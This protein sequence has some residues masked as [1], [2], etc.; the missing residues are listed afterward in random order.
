MAF[1]RRPGVPFLLRLLRVVSLVVLAAIGTTILMREAPGYFTDAR[2]TD[3]RYAG[4]ARARLDRQRQQESSLLQLSVSTLRH[5]SHGDLGQSRQ[6]GLSVTSMI[7]SRAAASVRLLF[8][9]VAAGWL[10]SLMLA[11]PLA[12]RRGSRGEALIAAPVAVMLAIPTGA[13]ATLCLL[14]DF[15]GPLLVLATI[16]AVRD[17][18]LVYRLLRQTWSDPCLLHARAQGIPTRRILLIHLL[19][20]L[21]SRLIAL[22]SMSFVLALSAL[23]PVEVIFNVPGL[24][25][26]A[27]TAAMNRDLPVLLAVTMVMAACVGAAGLAG[28]S[29]QQTELA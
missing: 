1:R 9:S 29:L 6:Y 19:P 25:Q 24:G 15:G 14:A 17:F 18:K 3:A 28:A 10:L 5:W 16:V 4:I 8:L 13:L 22:G 11:L 2:T 7:A 27:F 12:A 21:R 20:R 23:V 26:L